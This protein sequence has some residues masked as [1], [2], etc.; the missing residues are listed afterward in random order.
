[1]K[2]VLVAVSLVVSTLTGWTQSPPPVDLDWAVGTI[3]DNG[4]RLLYEVLPQ[5][6]DVKVVNSTEVSTSI[7]RMV[8][9][10]TGFVSLR[11]L[12]VVGCDETTGTTTLVELNGDD[13]K[14]VPIFNWSKDGERVFDSMATMTCIAVIMSQVQPV[15][16]AE[17]IKTPAPTKHQR[18][19]QGTMA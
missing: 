19:P 4:T 6:A 12:L 7:I 9:V 5:T 11:R 17:S 2:K 8:N 13:I 16:P 3:L 1:M 15:K 10:D 18:I 14:G